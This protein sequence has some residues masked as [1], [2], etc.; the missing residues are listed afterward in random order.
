MSKIRVA[1]FASGS[2]TNAECIVNYFKGHNQIEVSIILSNKPD[3]YVLQ[4]AADL[5]VPSHVFGRQE[6]YESEELINFLS[7]R[8]IDAIVLAGFLWLIP[9]SLI[10]NYLNKIINI[11]PALLPA[12]G[13]KG[14]YGERVHRAIIKNGEW[15]SGI[16]IHL[17]NERYDE[18]AILLQ[19]DCKVSSVDTPG[20]LAQ[21][22]HQLEYKHY[23]NV[24]EDYLLK[25]IDTLG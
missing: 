19:A 10:K 5:N 8:N 4:R 13:G 1:I 25:Y 16:T 18:G 20:S 22:I 24:I 12:F 3:A 9:A 21:K 7:E 23:P 14:M 15:R 17:V 6:L 2:G 11:H